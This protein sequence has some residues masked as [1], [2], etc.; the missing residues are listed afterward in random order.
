M[1]RSMR[2]RELGVKLRG[3]KD[4][5]AKRAI[6]YHYHEAAKA[7]VAAA[8]VARKAVTANNA[9]KRAAAK[10]NG[11]R[12]KANATASRMKRLNTCLDRCQHVHRHKVKPAGQLVHYG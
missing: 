6:R 4:A 8:A 7:R 2:R 3:T 10:A 9:K 5:V 12:I 11:E 1:M